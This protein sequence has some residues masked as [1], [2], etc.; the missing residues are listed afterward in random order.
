MVPAFTEFSVWDR[1]RQQ[2]WQQK[3]NKAEGKKI[4]WEMNANYINQRY[5]QRGKTGLF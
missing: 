1:I 3:I 2:T 5:Y 4:I